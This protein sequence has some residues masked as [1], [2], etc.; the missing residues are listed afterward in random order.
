MLNRICAILTLSLLAPW[1]LA[2]P[3]GSDPDGQTRRGSL[4]DPELVPVR[5]G[6]KLP[7]PAFDPGHDPFAVVIRGDPVPLQVFFV[8]VLPEEALEIEVESTGERPTLRYSGGTILSESDRGWVWRA[9]SAP[10]VMAL[11]LESSVSGESLSLNIF[12]LHPYQL[13]RSG[14]L[15]GYRIGNYAERPLRGDSVYL[16]PPGF[17]EIRDGDEDILVSPHFTIGQ[18]LCKQPGDPKYL[19]LSRYLVVKLEAI[20]KAVND[21]GFAVPGLQVM[22]GFRT[23]WYNRSIGNR[24]TFSRHLYGGAADIF[25]DVD[26]DGVMDD[27]NGDGRSTVDDA[28]I[29]LAIVKRVEASVSPGVRPGGLAAYRRNSARGPYVH[30]DARGKPAR[31]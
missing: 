6:D 17:I 2:A 19:A 16:P 7:G 23:P 3:I 22:S 28:D 29:L 26:E 21:A 10:G 30:V 13:V 20:L 5:H 8:S 15:N 18:F 1:G 31:W 14:V 25:L 9:P 24:T 11:R 27:L 4:L 12:V